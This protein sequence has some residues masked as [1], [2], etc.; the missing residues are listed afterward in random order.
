MPQRQHYP[1]NDERYQQSS[2]LASVNRNTAL[3]GGYIAQLMPRAPDNVANRLYAALYPAV[4][5]QSY[6]SEQSQCVYQHAKEKEVYQ[7]DNE[8]LDEFKE[9]LPDSKT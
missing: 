1:T 5:R 9:D 4:L 3:C 7:I 6:Q 2:S 8:L